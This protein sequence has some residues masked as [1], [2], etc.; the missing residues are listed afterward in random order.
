MFKFNRVLSLMLMLSFIPSKPPQTEDIQKLLVWQMN[1]GTQ[2]SNTLYSQFFQCRKTEVTKICIVRAFSENVH[3]VCKTG[4]EYIE[5]YSH[6]M[7]LQGENNR[8]CLKNC[9]KKLH[10][11]TTATVLVLIKLTKFAV[12]LRL[13]CG[14]YK[15]IF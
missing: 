13:H 3:L 7:R 11:F 14:S 4:L 5:C 2:Y 10:G 12:A 8:N 15:L 9:L 6:G 1:K